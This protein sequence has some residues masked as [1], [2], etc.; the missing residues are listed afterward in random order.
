MKKKILIISLTFVLTILQFSLY[1]KNIRVNFLLLFLIYLLF[2]EDTNYALI[3]VG[4]GLLVDLFA[5]NFGSY[6]I[7]FLL[8]AIFL[9]Y[10]YNSI[11]GNNKIFTYLLIN[12][13]GLVIFYSS[14]Y[15]Y[16]LFIKIINQGF[17]FFEWNLIFKN[18]LIILIVHLFISLLLYSLTNIFSYKTRKKFT[19][20]GN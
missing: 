8:V 15:I 4:A 10:I 11:L 3:V 1:L 7:S 5:V 19:I 6:F 12:F 14:Y 18:F 16:N 17:Y 20:I 13:L 2:F 9:H